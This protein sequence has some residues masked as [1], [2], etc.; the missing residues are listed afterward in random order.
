M[1]KIICQCPVETTLRLLE[2]KWRA[3]II[4]DLL[5]GTKRFGELKKSLNGISQRSLAINLRFME[6]YQLVSRKVYA[7]VPP[8]VEYTLT[9]TGE[10][11]RPVL[12]SMLKWGKKYQED[13]YP[14]SSPS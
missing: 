11:L 3:L 2:N 13:T 8:R 10:S 5:S 4:W 1:K 9:P 7:E 14:E 6:E 12:Q